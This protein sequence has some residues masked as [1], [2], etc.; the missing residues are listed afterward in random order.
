MKKILLICSSS[1]SIVSFRKNLIC[2][3][4]EC[5]FEVAAIAFDGTQREDIEKLG[6]E[7][8]V[9]NDDNRSVNPFKLL[10][11]IGKYKKIITKIQPDAVFTFMLKPNIYGTRAAQKAGVKYIFSMV[12]GA[13]DVFGKTGIKWKIIKKYCCRGYR[14][15]FRCSRKVFFTNNDDKAEFIKLKLV[16]LEKTE[17]INGIGVDV[18][19]FAYKPI[20]DYKTFLMVARMIESKGIFDYCKAAR[21][22]KRKFPYAVFNYIGGEQTI[23]LDDIKQFTDDGSVNYLGTT[24]DIKRFYEG[25]TVQ[26]LPTYYREGLGLVNA[27]AGAVGRPTITCDVV[28]ARDTVIDGYN[29]F[30]VRP[31][32]PE[33]LAEKMMFF[34]EN[35]DKAD[36]MGRNNRKFVE[37]KFDQRKINDRITDIISTCMEDCE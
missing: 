32:N 2:Q 1:G 31:K 30:F 17:T 10:S 34:L 5:G 18:D 12:E 7:L 3:V 19:V 26:V 14:H 28:G 36:E 27:E 13:G 16:D 4:Q 25:C 33:D 37:S 24:D 29:G 35:P 9:I 15:G 6:V 22:V 11:L 23:T 21:I 20:T 8:H